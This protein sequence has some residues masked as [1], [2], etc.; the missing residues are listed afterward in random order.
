MRK[1]RRHGIPV[2]AG[3]STLTSALEGVLD[4]VARLLEVGLALVGLA[5]GLHLAVVTRV[6]QLLLALAERSLGLVLELVVHG[7]SLG[8]TIGYPP[9]GTSMRLPLPWF[10][11]AL[12]Q[13]VEHSPCKRKVVSSNLT[14]GSTPRPRHSR[15]AARLPR[16]RA[17]PPPGRSG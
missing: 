1:G 2:P 14:S 11:A 13:L 4:L 12:A 10:R 7:T 15:R 3:P 17:R 6:A 9:S 8:W 5:F 16:G